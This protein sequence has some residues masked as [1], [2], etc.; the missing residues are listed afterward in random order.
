MFLIEVL[1]EAFG[2]KENVLFIGLLMRNF[3]MIVCYKYVSDLN[4]SECILLISPHFRVE[5]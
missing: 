2:L 5:M 4:R 3:D 1:Q